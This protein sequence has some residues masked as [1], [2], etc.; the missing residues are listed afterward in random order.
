MTLHFW[1]GYHMWTVCRANMLCRKEIYNHKIINQFDMQFLLVGY[2]TWTG[3]ILSDLQFC[4]R[5]HMWTLCRANM[6]CRKEIY[7]HK[8]RNQHLSDLQFLLI[9]YHT[10]TGQTCSVE[11]KYITEKSFCCLWKVWE[12]WYQHWF[13]DNCFLIQISREVVKKTGILL[14]GRP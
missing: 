10:C 6:L 13:T 14:S 9:G 7:N 3:K 8:T 4:V 12:Y 1:V 2:H 11:E 5:C